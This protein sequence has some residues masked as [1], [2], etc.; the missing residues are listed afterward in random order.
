MR[1]VDTNIIV[2]YLIADHPEQTAQARRLIDHEP[3]FVSSTVLLE[4][5]WVLR[6]LYEF[7]RQELISALKAFTGLPLITLENPSVVA[8]ALDLAGEGLDFADAL[9]VMV[10][11]GCT[12]FVTF[13]QDLIRRAREIETVAV[14]AP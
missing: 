11:S 10:A 4:T 14:Q 6:R 7:R 12:A 5:E 2:R 9:H 8:E 13:D 1:A 3:F